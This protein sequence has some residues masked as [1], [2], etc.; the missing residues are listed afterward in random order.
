[1]SSPSNVKKGQLW[2]LAV[3]ERWW[4][5]EYRRKVIDKG[6]A[7]MGEGKK[8]IGSVLLQLVDDPDAVEIN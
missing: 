3:T 5:I 1:M 6:A 8:C 4:W 7:K 2:Q